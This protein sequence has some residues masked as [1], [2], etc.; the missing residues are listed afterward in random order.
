MVSHETKAIKKMSSISRY[1]GP[2][3]C[4][5]RSSQISASSGMISIEEGEMK[6]KGIN[7]VVR[8]SFLKRQKETS[9]NPYSLKIGCNEYRFVIE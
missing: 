3:I 1:A 8:F 6:A 5:W 4:A 2:G 9:I 7:I